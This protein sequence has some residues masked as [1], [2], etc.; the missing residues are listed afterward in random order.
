MP[1]KKFEGKMVTKE[2]RTRKVA[3]TTHFHLPKVGF[4][5]PRGKIKLKSS[6]LPGNSAVAIHFHRC[7]RIT[8]SGRIACRLRPVK[9]VSKARTTIAKANI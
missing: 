7:Q 6:Q 2:R 8:S 3:R 1:P 5:S 4:Q 9:R